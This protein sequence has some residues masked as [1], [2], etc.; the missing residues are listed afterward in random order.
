[1]TDSLLIVTDFTLDSD[2][3]CVFVRVLGRLCTFC[4]EWGVCLSLLGSEAAFLT[5]ER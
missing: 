3:Q 4:V 1:M 2:A 5:F